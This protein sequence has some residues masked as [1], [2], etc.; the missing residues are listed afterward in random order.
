[1][2]RKNHQA[3][4][5]FRRALEHISDENQSRRLKLHIVVALQ[6]CSRTE[7]ALEVVSDLKRLAP[8]DTEILLAEAR[9]QSDLGNTLEAETCLTSIL[10][11]EPGNIDAFDLLHKIPGREPDPAVLTKIETFLD[12]S[13]I[14]YR[15]EI[16]LNFLAG[17]ICDKMK[18]FD[19]AFRYFKRANDR[20][21]ET[22]GIFDVRSH[23]DLVERIK[24]VFDG[25]LV[26]RFGDRDP[27]VEPPIFIL[28]MP[29]SGT[30]LAEQILAA[31]HAIHGVGEREELAHISGAL[32]HRL[33]SE[34]P[35]P[36]CM[37]EL[38]LEV[39]QSLAAEYLA[40]VSADVL[41]NLRVTDKMPRN[42]MDI[43]LIRVLFPDAPIIHCMR[44]PLDTCLSCYVSDFGL[45]QKFSTGFSELAEYY[46]AYRDLMDHWQS[47]LDRPVYDLQYEDLVAAPETE[48]PKLIDYCGLPWDENCL[49]PHLANRPVI[50]ASRWQVRQ[51]IYKS[52]VSRS[53]KYAGHL[54]GLKSALRL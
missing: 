18:S 34:R 10:A 40:Q 20:R 44:D 30:S 51:P 35:Y 28:G 37:E 49:A 1:M 15:D 48:I 33:G 23:L 14:D 4:A 9:L 32:G 53:V 13:S 29:R 36:D 42:F 38:G 22:N 12:D 8:G 2:Q 47:V 54:D 3:L 52:S 6:D 41:E 24:S 46:N 16:R 25:E 19:S 21:R 27:E 26:S 31:H 11:Q 5:V 45:R 39:S 7:E 43:G 50:T 17:E